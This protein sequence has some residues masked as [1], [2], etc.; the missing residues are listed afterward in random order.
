VRKANLIGFATWE[1][2]KSS[3]SGAT[4]PP[5]VGSIVSLKSVS[6]LGR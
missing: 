1:S 5:Q 4:Y 6:T 3:D 2:G